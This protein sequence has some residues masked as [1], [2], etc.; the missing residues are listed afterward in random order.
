MF[1]VA[2]A[3]MI[4]TAPVSAGGR[5]SSCWRAIAHARGALGDSPFGLRVADVAKGPY[6]RIGATN[7][8]S[9]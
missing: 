9:A 3:G 5:S 7:D 8:V 2:E 1:A 4:G 6:Q